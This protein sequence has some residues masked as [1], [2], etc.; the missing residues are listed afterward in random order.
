MI[1]ISIILSS[2]PTFAS[3]QNP[4][5]DLNGCHVLVLEIASNVSQT[6]ATQVST[7]LTACFSSK[8]L[9]FSDSTETTYGNYSLTL[10]KD[11]T[12]VAHYGF[13][14]SQGN[15]GLGHQ[16]FTYWEKPTTVSVAGAPTFS[17]STTDAVDYPVGNVMG[18]LTITVGQDYLG[19][20]NSVAYGVIK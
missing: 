2:T 19:F 15:G 12:Q 4:S 1:L 3:T 11:A 8:D 5:N 20:V 10:F 18:R 14:A 16:S 17:Y 7:G 9:S 6:S 13:H